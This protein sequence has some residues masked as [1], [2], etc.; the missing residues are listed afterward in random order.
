MRTMVVLGLLLALPASAA[1]FEDV[2]MGDH[3]AADA[4]SR[5]V[6]AGILQG[7]SD[8]LFHGEQGVTRYELAVALDRLR[9]AQGD[10]A[11]GLF[12]GLMGELKT[13]ASDGPAGRL[14]I[15]GAPLLGLLQGLAD[16]ADGP[17]GDAARERA[18][19]LLEQLDEALKSFRAEE[20]KAARE[21]LGR[22]ADRLETESDALLKD[23]TGPQR[24]KAE[25]LLDG[26]R[27]E[28]DQTRRE[29]QGKQAERIESL[30]DELLDQGR[31][32]RDEGLPQAGEKVERLVDRVL[33]EGQRLW[34]SPEA[35]KMR[36]K[37][38]NKLTELV[39]SAMLS[40]LKMPFGMPSMEVP[41]EPM[42]AAPEE[43]AQD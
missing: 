7:R 14:S 28:L 32:M 29:L 1:V 5:L 41:S 17:A 42:T 11:L 3:W 6:D 4:V 15:Q 10:P 23:L 12:T 21:R 38:L 8:G 43:P 33:T 37:V 34:E 2:P 18:R 22:M 13:A 16:A 26:L 27:E 19:A 24:E 30:L 20:L 9:K 40:Q 25:K 39:M 36:G 31:Q 35:T